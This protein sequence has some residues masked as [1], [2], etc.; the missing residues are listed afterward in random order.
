MAGD[1]KLKYGTPTD[2]TIT[3]ASLA[4]SA[5]LVAGRGSTSVSNI[6]DVLLDALVSGYITA[7]TTLTAGFLEVWAYAQVDDTP[8]YPNVLD[9]TDSAETFASRDIMFASMK[10]AHRIVTSTTNSVVYPVQPFSIARLFGGMPR[11]WGVFVTHSMVGA[12][13]ASGHKLQYT[14]LIS[15]YT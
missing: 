6:T 9:G 4:T 7:G 5:S 11:R 15:Q 10:M 1:I 3:L 12:L 8:T 14:P 13:A 2:L